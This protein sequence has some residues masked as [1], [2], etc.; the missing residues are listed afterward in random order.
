MKRRHLAT[1]AEST[2]ARMSELATA[3]D[4]VAELVAELKA[5]AVKHNG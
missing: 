5:L 3:R 2:L 1:E 4:H